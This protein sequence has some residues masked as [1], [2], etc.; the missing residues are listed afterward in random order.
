MKL[1][2]AIAALVVAFTGSVSAAPTAENSLL[3]RAPNC[4]A[5]GFKIKDVPSGYAVLINYDNNA[6]DIP[7]SIGQGTGITDC[8]NQ[9]KTIS[10][11]TNTVYSPAGDN[12][13]FCYP[14]GSLYTSYNVYSKSPRTFAVQDTCAGAVTAGKST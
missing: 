7:A 2:I 9:C 11:C 3:K 14:K 4:N 5:N 10:G 1:S 6:A 13:G 8:I 12:W